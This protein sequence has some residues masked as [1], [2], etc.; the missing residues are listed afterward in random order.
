M[1]PVTC[2]KA[3]LDVQKASA[4]QVHAELCEKYGVDSVELIVFLPDRGHS[5]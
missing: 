1:V 3:E 2:A 5:P 4:Q